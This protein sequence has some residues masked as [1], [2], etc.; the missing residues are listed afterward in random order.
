MSSNSE[1]MR[2]SFIRYAIVATAVAVIFLLV[3]RDNVVRWIQ[4][5]FTL[6]R[7]EQQIELLKEQNAALDRKVDMMSTNKDTLETYAREEFF[8]SAPGDDVFIVE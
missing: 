6:R 8:F 7:Q 2:K 3:K 1:D 5:G 4:A